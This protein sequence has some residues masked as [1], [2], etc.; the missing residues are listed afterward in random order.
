MLRAGPNGIGNKGEMSGGE[1]FQLGLE[2]KIV[3]WQNNG[4][5]GNSI[6]ESLSVCNASNVW[7]LQ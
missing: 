7:M 1:F 6:D 2:S 5:G 3:L 4:D